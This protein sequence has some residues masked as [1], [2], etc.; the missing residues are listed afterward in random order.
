[1]GK[2]RGIVLIDLIERNS[3]KLLQQKQIKLH[4]FNILRQM[5][6]IFLPLKKGYRPDPP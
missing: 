1:M 6:S 5:N 2:R 3:T 4:P